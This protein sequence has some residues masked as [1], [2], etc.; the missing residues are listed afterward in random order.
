MSRIPRRELLRIVLFF[1]YTNRCIRKT[2][3]KKM[4]AKRHYIFNSLKYE[5]AKCTHSDI[6]PG[7][8]TV[9]APR[10][11]PSRNYWAN[12]MNCRITYNSLLGLSCKRR[13][14]GTNVFVRR[15]KKTT[16]LFIHRCYIR[17][18][19]ISYTKYISRTFGN[20]FTDGAQQRWQ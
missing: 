10:S 17:I 11:F 2:I 19:T 5:R 16:I 3:A 7:F 13:T 20:D 8:R 1:F 9:W 6:L 15:I 4:F 14:R 18:T 12:K